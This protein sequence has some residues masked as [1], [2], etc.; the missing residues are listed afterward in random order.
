ME[1][2]LNE[3]SEEEISNQML[4]QKIDDELN[5]MDKTELQNMVNDILPECKDLIRNTA[6]LESTNDLTNFKT[7]IQNHQYNTC[8]GELSDNGKTIFRGQDENE[9]LY[10]YT[11]KKNENGEITVSKKLIKK[12]KMQN[13]E[14]N[15][16]EGVNNRNPILSIDDN[17]MI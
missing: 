2:K 9:N 17:E 16:I 11:A 1:A 12:S 5:N 8:M 15:S 10:E 13:K 14:K 6:I 3:I 4:E 7:D